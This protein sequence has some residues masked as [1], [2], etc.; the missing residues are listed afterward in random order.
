MPKKHLNFNTS[1][2]KSSI[3]FEIILLILSVLIL[4]NIWQKV[5]KDFFTL[6]FYVKQNKVTNK[7]PNNYETKFVHKNRN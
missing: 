2:I 4:T 5:V 1:A 7:S 6:L 3:A